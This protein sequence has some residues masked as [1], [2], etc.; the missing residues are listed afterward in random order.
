MSSL[1]TGVKRCHSE[2]EPLLDP[3]H[4]DPAGVDVVAVQA[5]QHNTVLIK[6]KQVAVSVLVH[7]LDSSLAQSSLDLA[8]P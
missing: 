3:G 4:A 5:G 1:T 8:S 2:Y 6:G 7:V